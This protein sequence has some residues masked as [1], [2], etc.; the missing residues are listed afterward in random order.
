MKYSLRFILAIFLWLIC[1]NAFSQDQTLPYNQTL[2]FGRIM[3]DEQVKQTLSF[4]NPTNKL[5]EIEN[6][7][8]TH[9]LKAKIL[10]KKIAPGEQGRFILELDKDR[11]Y[12]F[13]EGFIRI[14]FKKNIHPPLI[15]NVEGNF[16]PPIEFTPKPL[17]VAVT[18]RGVPKHKS[19]EII[20]HTENP[21]QLTG[22]E[23]DSDRFVAQLSTL[24]PGKHYKIDLMLSGKEKGGRKSE[25][26]RILN[27][28]KKTPALKLMV[29]TLITEKVYTFPEIVNLGSFP[30]KIAKNPAALDQLAQTLMIYN[31]G[32][33][34]FEISA[35][36]DLENISYTYQRGSKGDR[37]QF[38]IKLLPE[39]VKAGPIK[40]SIF[41]TTNDPDFP[42][43]NVPVT[44]EIFVN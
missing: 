8:L 7:Q 12:G 29:K 13:Y 35:S 42:L 21:L 20:N 37:Y 38:T 11:T 18:K 23:Y 1:A 34:D 19:V 25:W 41:I 30:L 9:P 6:I 2:S 27:E 15:F 43:I 44:G 16:V 14:N 22:I 33:S 36:S 17:I 5:L 28:D 26:I 3:F 24:I 10:T 39:K 31:K 4:S 40:G 32:V